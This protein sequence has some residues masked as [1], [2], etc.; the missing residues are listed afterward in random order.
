MGLAAFSCLL[1][2]T[3]RLL[4]RA[5]RRLLTT[6]PDL[7]DLP[8]AFLLAIVAYVAC[9]LFLTL[10]FER[11]F[12]LLM[13]LAAASAAIAVDRSRRSELGARAVT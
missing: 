5:R 4:L 10:A 8:T 7:A 13:A 6:R 2:V 9:G 11:Y 3:A 1:F 12:W